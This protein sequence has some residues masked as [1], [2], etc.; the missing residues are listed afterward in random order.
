MAVSY[1]NKHT[2]TCDPAILLRYIYPNELKKQ[3]TVDL[4]VVATTWRQVGFP[5]IGE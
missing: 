4:F 3:T 2:L 5:S 1:E